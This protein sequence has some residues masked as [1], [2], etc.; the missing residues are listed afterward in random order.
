MRRRLQAEPRLRPWRRL[1]PWGGEYGRGRDACLHTHT[2]AH[3]HVHT[4]THT[5]REVPPGLASTHKHTHT[6]AQVTR[7]YMPIHTHGA[8]CHQGSR[9]H[10]STPTHERKRSPA[11]ACARTHTPSHIRT[12]TPKHKRNR[13][14]AR[15]RARK[16]AHAHTETQRVGGTAEAGVSARA[17]P[18]TCRRSGEGSRGSGRAHWQPGNRVSEREDVLTGG[19]A[20]GWEGEWAGERGDDGGGGAGNGDNGN[21]DGN[22]ETSTLPRMSHQPHGPIWPATDGAEAPMTASCSEGARTVRARRCAV[23]SC[24]VPRRG[25]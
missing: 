10:T 9:T 11:R 23:R 2:L 14:H 17:D 20:G 4:Y 19:R 24:P 22:D 15:A 21:G 16:H 18:A 25:H 7:T 5:W 3:T 13:S 1:K 6:R 8:G 12:Q